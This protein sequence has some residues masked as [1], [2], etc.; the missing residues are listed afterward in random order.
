MSRQALFK[1]YEIDPN[2]SLVLNTL[3][4][5][6][7]KNKEYSKFFQSLQLAQKLNPL[8]PHVISILITLNAYIG[9]LNDNMN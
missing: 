9:F 2:S 6:Y 5:F 1:A 3:I 8:N 7:Y 4:S